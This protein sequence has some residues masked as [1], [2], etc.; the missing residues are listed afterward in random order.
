MSELLLKA[1]DNSMETKSHMAGINI[2]Q[3]KSLI[4]K[5]RL[6]I[7][8][9]FSIFQLSVCLILLS[10]VWSSVFFHK[11]LLSDK[12]LLGLSAWLTISSLCPWIKNNI[13]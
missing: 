6:Y 8:L 7:S 10:S 5:Y 12:W 3:L 9:G 4:Q 13:D 2:E 11:F 1:D